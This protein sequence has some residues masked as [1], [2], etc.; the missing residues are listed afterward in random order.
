[1]QNCPPQ[2]AMQSCALC[3]CVRCEPSNQIK[4]EGLPW[5]L[6][7]KQFFLK[8]FWM[9]RVFII[10]VLFRRRYVV[11]VRSL[12][13]QR[14]I[15]YI[16]NK[17]LMLSMRSSQIAYISTKSYKMKLVYPEASI[18]LWMWRFLFWYYQYAVI[19]L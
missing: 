1:M 14:Q 7:T 19:R 5:R 17:M 10:H 18:N 8:T 16:W 12:F 2:I 4:Q 3:L 6:G 15:F 11:I 13:L 9:Q